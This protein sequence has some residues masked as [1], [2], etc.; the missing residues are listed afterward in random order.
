[1]R[2]V[3]AIGLVL[4]TFIICLVFSLTSIR[5]RFDYE[6]NSRIFDSISDLDFLNEFAL[7]E[8]IKDKYI[9]DIE[10][11]DSRTVL[12]DYNGNKI[13]IYAYDFSSV[14]NCLEYAENVSGNNYLYSYNGEDI[15]WYYYEFSLFL[16]NERLLVFYN[17]KAYVL[18]ARLSEQEFN[19]FVVY[20]MSK[21]PTAVQITY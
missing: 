12:A 15:A 7:D 10:F 18:S 21:M 13:R 2:K 19:E 6:S 17:D 8:S 11:D 3:F 16:L 14:E 9:S 5:N 1:M 20:F 4:C